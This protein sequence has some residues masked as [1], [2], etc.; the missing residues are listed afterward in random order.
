M[1]KFLAK[2]AVLSLLVVPALSLAADE[3][4]APPLQTQQTAPV[5]EGAEVPE[6]ELTGS[7]VSFDA[8]NGEF[9]ILTEAHGEV[10]VRFEEGVLPVDKLYPGLSVVVQTN[11]VMTMSLPGQVNALAVEVVYTEGVFT[12]Y[13]EAGRMLVE[14][15]DG[16]HAFVFGDDGVLVDGLP[17]L[18]EGA[19]VQVFHSAASTRSIP[20]Q[21]AA[22]LVRVLGEAQG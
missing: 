16:P 22:T 1:K 20:P 4:A 17:L 18:T 12:G 11:G 9:L 2:L 21:S 14:T 5:S 19:L 8:E 3:P 10:L 6:T 7:V 15:E 13:D